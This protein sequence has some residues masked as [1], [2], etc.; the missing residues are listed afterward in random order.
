M[1]ENMK[2]TLDRLRVVEMGGIGAAPFCAMM[3]A[4]MGAAVLRIPRP[5]SDQAASRRN[6]RCDV[7]VLFC[8]ELPLL[9]SLQGLESGRGSAD[10]SW[11]RPSVS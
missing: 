7:L 5:E 9:P 2:G 8:P 6:A 11:S 10:G 1:I 4:D 3:L